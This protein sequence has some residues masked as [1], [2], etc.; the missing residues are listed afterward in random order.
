MSSFDKVN[1]N[2][3]EKSDEEREIEFK[4]LKAMHDRRS[5]PEHRTKSQ[6]AI[7]NLDAGSRT[8][9]IPPLPAPSY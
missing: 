4:M 2:G 6:T 1:L 5:T 3:M 7:Y 8:N 9:I